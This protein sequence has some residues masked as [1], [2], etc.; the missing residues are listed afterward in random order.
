MKKLFVIIVLLSG[1]AS[2]QLEKTERD[3]TGNLLT[4]SIS[5][6]IGGA[7]FVTGTFAAS[8]FERVDQFVTRIFNYYKVQQIGSLQ[9]EDDIEERVAEIENFAKRD[10]R[11][12]RANG[13]ETIVD[14][15]RFRV[16]GDFAYNPYLKN[17]DVIIFPRLDLDRNFFSINGAVNNPVKVQYV[18]G[19]KLSD[20]LLFAQGL[21][22]AYENVTT[23]EIHRLSYNGDSEEVITVKLNEDAPLK[24]GD[25]IIVVADETNRKDFKVLVLG[26]VNKPGFIP[27]TKNTTTIKELINKAG[28]FTEKAAIYRA[29]L[30]RNRQSFLSYQQYVFSKNFEKDRINN[31][32][33]QVALYDIYEN[34][35]IEELLM[36]RSSAVAGEDSVYF[37]A[38]NTLRLF[39]TRSAVDF[40]KIFSDDSNEGDY[41]VRHGDIIIIPE[42]MNQI[43]MFGQ[44]VVPGYQPFIEGESLEH[45]INKAGGLT[46]SAKGMK[47]TYLI[48]GKT[49]TW[50]KLSKNMNIEA[51]DFIY[52][53][54]DVPKPFGQYLNEALPFASIIGT[55]ATIILVV[56]QLTNKN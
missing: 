9:D 14:L 46:Q 23:A 7:F 51:G 35:M 16:T 10:I 13:P 1:I 27:I 38:D 36:N 8:P 17:D 20:A 48:K 30:I 25:R 22:E 39:Q 52:V 37:N 5:V 32:R 42:Q 6:T 3:A 56:V 15:E 34:H 12:K 4:N 18:A 45:Y 11:I 44:V 24:R 53:P 47:D 43:Y 31:E 49:R 54:R 2:A 41:I 40:T 28:G 50:H 29:D 21:D 19:D 55:L 33:F 26:E